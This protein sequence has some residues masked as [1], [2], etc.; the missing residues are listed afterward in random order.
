MERRGRRPR[1]TRFIRV[2]LVLAATVAGTGL[3]G[4]GGLAA[5]Q[6]YTENPANTVAAGTVT[7]SNAVGSATC[8]SVTSTT[9]LNETGN[10][11]AAII[12]VTGVDPASPATLATGG[13]KI[14]STGTL[15]ST[16]TMQMAAAPT[17]NLCADLVLT[18]VDA[19]SVTD[20]PPVPATP[21]TTQMGT[22]ALNDSAGASNWPGTAPGPAGSDTYTFTI[23]RGANFN[24]DASDAG[25]SCGFSILFTQVA[26]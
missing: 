22:I 6:G 21:L 1:R 25:Q 23:T 17:G 3:V 13:V 24:T 9:L 7:H 5:W 15:K 14:T 18:V 16:F 26:S 4:F 11:C 20:Y 19:S 12:N 10:V 2:T 8:T